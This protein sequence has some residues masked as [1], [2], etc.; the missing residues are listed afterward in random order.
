M[1]AAAEPEPKSFDVVVYGATPAGVC[2]A[3][4]ASREGATVALLEPMDLVG[5]LMA[6]GLS[7][8]DS[9]QMARECLLGLFEEFH[10]RVENAY[11]AAGVMLPYRVRDKDHKPWTYEPH[12]AEAVFHGMLREGKVATF[13]KQDIR[14]IVKHGVRI[15]RLVTTDGSTIAGRVFIDAS[16]EGDLLALAKVSY[17]VGREGPAAY[18]ES[19]AGHQ[20]PKK[21]VRVSPW[22]DGDR[23]LPLMSGREPAPPGAGDQKI[24]TY[25]FRLCLT[26]DADHRVPFAKPDGY[27][28]ARFELFRRYFEKHGDAEFPIDLYPLPGGKYDANNGIG[29]QLSLGLVGASWEW[30]EATPLRRQQLWQEHRAYTQGL[31]WFLGNDPGVPERIRTTAGK[32]GLATDEFAKYGHWPPVL[33]VREARRMV[34]AYVLTQNDIRT[35][36]TKPDPVGVGSF[37]IDSHDCQRVP[38]EGGGFVNEGTIFPSH[39]KGRPIGQPH[40]LPYRCL[41]PKPE[42]CDNLLVPVC[43]SASHVAFCSVRVEPTWMVLGQSSG[44]AAALIARSDVPAQK[45]PYEQ[46]KPR[47][48]AGKQSLELPE[49]PK[50]GSIDLLS[51]LVVVACFRDPSRL[52]L[53]GQR[54]QGPRKHGIQPGT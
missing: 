1:T 2:A 47:L 38:G 45:L 3:V 18:H 26:S 49:L 50:V 6:S 27:D 30:P 22:A 17:R 13:L 9:N 4:A 36:V 31:L 16:Y 54:P 12:V 11:V 20:Y 21:E 7:F 8:S 32:Y 41:V 52:W 35:D 28:P 29:K 48:Q 42:E 23:L 40:H 34:G 43:L 15:K 25:S 24:M 14:S 5:G 10:Q 19:L 39:I 46:L 51:E 53:Y 33:Y 37:P 44:I